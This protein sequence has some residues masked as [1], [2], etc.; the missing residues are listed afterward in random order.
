MTWQ[1]YVAVFSVVVAVVALIVAAVTRVAVGPAACRETATLRA[2]MDTGCSPHACSTKPGPQAIPRV[3]YRTGPSHSALT[4][5]GPTKRAWDFTAHNNP[6]YAQVF[7]DDNEM[8][9][10]MKTAL[11]GKVYKAFKMLVPGAAK[12][13]LFRYCIMYE[14]GGVYLDNKSG[15]HRLCSL[16]RP[17]DKMLVSTWGHTFFDNLKRV[18]YGELEQWWLAS[19]PQNPVM[20]DVIQK[21]V[22]NIEA[23]TLSGGDSRTNTLKTTGP[24][25]FTTIV[26][27]HLRH[28]NGDV[29]LVCSD[30]NGTMIY[31]VQGGHWSGHGYS[32]LKSIFV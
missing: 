11:H 3:I 28:S 25:H 16:I 21:T 10:F 2:F 14:R 30:G 26:D 12:A 9:A 1:T 23:N 19:E 15:A 7:F 20:F 22:K 31:D 24:L 8:D 4:V 27:K 32:G 6:E 13:D 29:R 18:S 17:H 5:D